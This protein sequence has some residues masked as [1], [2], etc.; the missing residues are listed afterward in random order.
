MTLAVA[1]LLASVV[2]A[3]GAPRYLRPGSTPR[4]HPSLSLCAWL[5]AA[6]SMVAT[7]FSAA[8]I[9][10]SPDPAV[11]DGAFGLATACWRAIGRSAFPWLLLTRLVIGLTVLVLLLRIGSVLTADLIDGSR[12]RRDHARTLRAVARE[13]DG[14]WWVPGETPLAFSIGRFRRGVVV[15]ST[16]VEHLDDDVAEAVLAHERAH[17]RGRHHLAVTLAH[18]MARALPRVPLCRA[19]PAAIS[20]LCEL[21]ADAAAVNAC[22]LPAVT[23]ALHSMAPSAAPP[24]VVGF[25]AH[26]QARVSW[27]SRPRSPML[28]RSGAISRGLAGTTALLPPL[29]SA[30]MAAASLTMLCLSRTS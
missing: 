12:R 15:A 13:A 20:V 6:L 24:S 26:L 19:A 9:L 23:G 3:A 7:A 11:P 25:G 28:Q 14:V 29:A 30:A 16:A 2:I 1:L 21:S 27:L 4:V 18:S 22:G 17:L 5:V 8:V 10:L